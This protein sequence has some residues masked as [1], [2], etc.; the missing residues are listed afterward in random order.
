MCGITGYNGNNQAAPVLLAGLEKLEYRGYDSA[1]IAVRDG[2]KPVEIVK[3][4]GRLRVLAEKTDEGIKFF[5][6]GDDAFSPF[7]LMWKESS[8]S[9]NGGTSSPGAGP[10]ASGSSYTAGVDGHWVHMSPEDINVPLSV[11]VPEGATPV[12]N[13]E[14]HQW[15]FFLN[16]GDMLYDQWAYVYN[17]YAVGDQP[18]EGWFSFANNGIMEYGWYLDER[19]G[20]WYWMH[21]TSD[22]MLGTMET[23][24]HYDGQDGRWYYLDPDGGEMLLG[25]QQIGG[26]WYYF[27]P[28]APAVTWNYD[29]ATGGWTYNGSDSRP[30]GSMYIN[31]TTPDGYTVDENGAWRN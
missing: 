22:G 19:T 30:Y 31:E 15:K 21:R 8:G 2:D 16:N 23:G 17:P 28:M 9:N 25:W 1:G 26:S 14:W 11:P 10:G 18:R 24:W 6:A 27:N 12:T 3:A 29:E 13:P 5:T 4:K 7:V 20:K